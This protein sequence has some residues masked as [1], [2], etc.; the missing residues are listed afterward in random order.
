MKKIFLI[1]VI[2]IGCAAAP[3]FVSHAVESA[4][5]CDPSKPCVYSGNAKADN[6]EVINIKVYEQNGSWVA[7]FTK[8]NQEYT[9]FVIADADGRCHV[10][11]NGR[12]YY[13]TI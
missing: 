7:T 1:V 6:G 8:N 13:F 11:Y 12:P 4:P 9:M 5:V 2:L 3:E 10:N